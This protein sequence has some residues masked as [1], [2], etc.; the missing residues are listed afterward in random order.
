M[1]VSSPRPGEFVVRDALE[2]GFP[3]VKIIPPEP[4]TKMY[5]ARPDTIHFLTEKHLFFVDNMAI[6]ATKS[7]VKVQN[8]IMKYDMEH[9]IL[10]GTPPV[11]TLGQHVLIVEPFMDGFVIE[12]T[13]GHI[14]VMDASGHFVSG[15]PEQLLCSCWEPYTEGHMLLY[16]LGFGGYGVCTSGVIYFDRIMQVVGIENTF[17]CN[18]RVTNGMFIH[19]TN[20]ECE[21]IVPVGPKQPMKIYRYKYPTVMMYGIITIV[22]DGVV[23]W[24]S[25]VADVADM[26]LWLSRT[27][28]GRFH[29]ATTRGLLARPIV[30][31][32]GID[33]D[34]GIALVMTGDDKKCGYAIDVRTGK[35]EANGE[36]LQI[37]K[38]IMRM[39]AAQ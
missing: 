32:L 25:P 16:Q 15:L 30:R 12:F 18:A 3:I 2:P 33:H 23:G 38:P 21:A 10:P 31:I 17:Y 28:D 39:I 27:P 35:I 24:R 19:F 4:L 14:S 6:V 7:L 29:V 5:L 13:D 36:G 1:F 20:E 9:G 8:Y 26:V 22:M 37:V 34:A 11:R